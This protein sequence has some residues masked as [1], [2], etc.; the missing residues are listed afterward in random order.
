MPSRASSKGRAPRRAAHHHD[1]GD[2][3]EEARRRRRI[4][5]VVIRAMVASWFLASV[6]HRA[7][8]SSDWERYLHYESL[9]VAR[10]VSPFFSEGM[11]SPDNPVLAAVFGLLSLVEVAGAVLFLLGH[12]RRGI[13]LLILYLCLSSIV[14]HHFWSA[15]SISFKAV[16]D[17]SQPITVLGL[18]LYIRTAIDAEE[19]AAEE[20][21]AG[22]APARRK[23]ASK[24][25]SKPKPKPQSK[26]ANTKKQVLN[27]IAA[28]AKTIDFATLG[29]ATASEQDDLQ[30]IKGVGPFIEEKLHALGI[31]TFLQISKMT[32]KIEDDVNIAIEFFIGRIRR[33]QWRKQAKAFVEEAPR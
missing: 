33:D 3:G 19:E 17:F 18:L 13:D 14:L 6:W 5:R 7:S 26:K 16:L 30:R 32:P 24:P 9:K 2:D 1:D 27:R 15:S 21:E 11:L 22:P 10:V 8:S 20:E 25:K 29:V 12:E 23:A 4:I 28:K 31:Y